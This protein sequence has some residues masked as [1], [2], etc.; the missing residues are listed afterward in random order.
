MRK[1]HALIVGGTK[2][3][4]RALVKV[5][6]E[7]KD[8]LSVIGRSLPP[9]AHRIPGA[10]YWALDLLDRERIEPVLTEITRQ[11]GKLDSLVFLQRYRGQGEAW[12]GEIETSLTAT[13]NVV[14]QLVDA[15]GDEG[16][17]S[18]VVVSSIAGYFI[19][20][21]QPL[22]YHVAKAAINQM[23]RYYAF[24][25]GPKGIRVNCVSSG[26]VLKEESKDF[27]L[28]NEQLSD[29]YKTIIPLGRMVT[30]ENVANV[31]AFLCSPRA[32]SITG[33]NII[34]DGGLSLEGQESLARRLAGQLHPNAMKLSR[35][36][37]K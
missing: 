9:E 37:S 27:Y 15:F 2:G 5:L 36:E 34:V 24:A 13:K 8:V 10:R 12:A 23:I 32:A 3:I 11:N 1:G 28:K 17:N 6:A 16:D 22:S 21:E 31:I 25:L 4:G 35:G 33:Q 20:E 30:A 19:A 26:T 7:E 18:I 29:L 14:E